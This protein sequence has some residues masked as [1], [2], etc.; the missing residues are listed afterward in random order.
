MA[1]VT[2]KKRPGLRFVLKY[3]EL[4]ND[5]FWYAF[6]VIFQGWNYLEPHSWE[7]EP[8]VKG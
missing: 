5:L 4:N 1:E 2:Y 8:Q 3:S 6:G 7:D